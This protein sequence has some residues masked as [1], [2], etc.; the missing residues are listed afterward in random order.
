M[1]PNGESH[2][3]PSIRVARNEE[4]DEKEKQEAPRKVVGSKP[5]H[6]LPGCEDKAGEEKPPLVPPTVNPGP[7]YKDQVRD[8]R[9]SRPTLPDYNDNRNVKPPRVQPTNDKIDLRLRQSGSGPTY[10]DQVRNSRRVQ[11]GTN[12]AQEENPS[13]KGQLQDVAHPPSGGSGGPHFKQ[14]GE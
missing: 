10:K 1:D 6:S 12:E 11:Q 9:R 13:T 2:P 5:Q 14:Q 4:D 3:S 7:T 8:T